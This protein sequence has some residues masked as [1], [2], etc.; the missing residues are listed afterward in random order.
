MAQAAAA[1]KAKALNEAKAAAEAAFQSQLLS[2]RVK[3]WAL[4]DGD[5]A[6]DVIAALMV[7]IG[8]V[9]EAAAATS[10]RDAPWVRQLHGALRTL[11]SLCIHNRY[12]WRIEAAPVIEAAIDLAEL[13]GRPMHCEAAFIEAWQAANGAAVLVLAHQV[14]EEMIA[15]AVDLSKTLNTRRSG[16]DGV[17]T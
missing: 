16:G 3:L 5:D 17:T 15:G 12:R 2:T 10:G 11:Q 4:A 7:V 14:D 1:A 13:H 8:T 9:C 6:T